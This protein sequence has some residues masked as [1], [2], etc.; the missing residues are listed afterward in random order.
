MFSPSNHPGESS[1]TQRPTMFHPKNIVNII[2]ETIQQSSSKNTGNSL[3]YRPYIWK[4][5]VG[6]SNQSVPEMAIDPKI[7][8]IFPIFSC[9]SG[10]QRRLSSLVEFSQHSQGRVW[11]GM[12]K[13]VPRNGYVV[14]HDFRRET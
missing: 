6:T 1:K 7:S 11:D 4:Y 2:L 9:A 10:R 12:G 14:L 3:K 8:M 13:C 5:M